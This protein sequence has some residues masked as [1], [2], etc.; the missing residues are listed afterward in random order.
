[1][2]AGSG[3]AGDDPAPS[4]WIE[5]G[6]VAGCHGVRGALRIRSLTRPPSAIADYPFW[7]IGDHGAAA[8]RYRLLRCHP[9]GR[10]ILATLEGITDRTAAE[11]VAG[12]R[13]FVPLTAA[14]ERTAPDE[15]LWHDLVGCRVDD[16]RLGGLGSIVRLEAYGA[17]D[18]LVVADA[19][20]GG[21]WML[22]YTHETIVR[23]DLRARLVTTDLPEGIEACFTLRS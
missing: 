2:E 22:P 9:H 1:M 15:T 18:I 3:T 12:G 13:I 8:R 10:G 17:S 5:V 19:R 11:G 4:C 20:R 7:W 16:L 14:R 6:A 21:E 23:V